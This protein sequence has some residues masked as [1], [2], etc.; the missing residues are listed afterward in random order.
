MR[1]ASE[2][3]DGV[4]VGIM[5]EGDIAVII[6]WDQGTQ[7]AGNIVTRC[8]SRLIILGKDEDTSYPTLF[9]VKRENQ[10]PERRIRILEKGT[11]LEV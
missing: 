2:Q 3:L 8:G 1:L 6:S 7:F 5:K 4:S 11:L 10:K 9:S